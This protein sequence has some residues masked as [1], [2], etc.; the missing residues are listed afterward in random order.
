M[1]SNTSLKP[2]VT[3]DLDISGSTIE[4]VVSFDVETGGK[5]SDN[6]DTFSCET[7]S[8]QGILSGESGDCMEM[9]LLHSVSVA[10][11]SSRV[12]EI[13]SGVTTAH[14]SVSHE[15]GLEV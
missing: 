10:H 11:E 6:I 3:L 5:L 14:S 15:T 9:S 13:V 8:V 12:D 4:R 1:L 7:S 2:A